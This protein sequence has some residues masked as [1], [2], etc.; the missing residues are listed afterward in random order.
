MLESPFY[1][2]SYDGLY[3]LITESDY[4]PLREDAEPN[5]NYMVS[6][7]LNKDPTKR[8]NIHDICTLPWMNKQI[9]EMC[10]KFDFTVP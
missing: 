6:I 2:D 1:D 8:P 3:K 7:M 4:K 10:K 5:L 9:M